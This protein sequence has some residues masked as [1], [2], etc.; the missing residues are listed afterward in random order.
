MSKVKSGWRKKSD[1]LR[2]M[3]RAFEGMPKAM[4]I[5]AQDHLHQYILAFHPI[6]FRTNRL[7]DSFTVD[8]ISRGVWAVLQAGYKPE[9]TEKI[10]IGYAQFRENDTAFGLLRKQT[11]TK[12]LDGI[13]AEF[14]RIFTTIEQGGDYKWN[15]KRFGKSITISN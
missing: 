13:M 2:Q 6:G 10:M 5:S 14:E 15:E 8:Y 12:F 9:Y 1:N 11:E 3:V 4:A 7:R